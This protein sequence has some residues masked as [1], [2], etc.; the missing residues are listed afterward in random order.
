MKLWPLFVFLTILCWGMYVPTLHHG[1]QAF[2]GRNG[3]LKAF[4]FVG[5]A[6]FLVA[7]V[8]PALLILISPEPA[9]FPSRG[10]SISTAAGALG[11]IGAL[12]IILAMREGGKPI[13]VA[14][15]VFAGA[16]IINTFVSM[17]WVRPEK[18]PDLRFYVGIALAAAGALMVLMYK[19]K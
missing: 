13:Y 12:G 18:S 6:Y 2:G 19:P 15:L 14:P 3:T 5:I 1:A 8:V 9:Q 10:V 4:L 7:I 17:I 16:P 11:A